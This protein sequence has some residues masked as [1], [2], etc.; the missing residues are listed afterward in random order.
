MVIALKRLTRN[1]PTNEIVLVET[2]YLFF[3]RHNIYKHTKSD[4]YQKFKL[5]VR[6]ALNLPCR[7]QPK[8]CWN[9][10]KIGCIYWFNILVKCI[11]V[12]VQYISK[13][14][15]IN[16][17]IE[18]IMCD[19]SNLLNFIQPSIQISYDWVEKDQFGSVM[20]C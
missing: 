14:Q 8:N 1:A 7:Y 17:F 2:C 15:K 16:M 11:G 9:L 13:M 20:C 12:L 3:Y 6:P 4:F 10:I 19:V 18:K 5:S